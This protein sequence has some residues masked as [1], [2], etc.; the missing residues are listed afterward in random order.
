MKSP[1]IELSGFHLLTG[2]LSQWANRRCCQAVCVNLFL[3]TAGL[4]NGLE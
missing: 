1:F 4:T 3:G 2:K